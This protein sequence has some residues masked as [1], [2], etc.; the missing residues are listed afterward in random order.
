MNGVDEVYKYV[1]FDF[2]GTLVDSKMTF[3]SSWNI[4]AKK[5]NY[6]EI[7]IDGIEELSNL[8]M[9][10]KMTWLNIPFYRIPFIAPKIYKLYR[11]SIHDI[12]LFEGIKDMLVQLEKKGYKT[13][14]ISSNSK[15]NIRFF[16][17]QN[18]IHSVNTIYCSSNIFGKD[19]L[20]YKFLRD[21]QLKSSDVIY[22]GDEQRDIVACK[23]I[24]VKIIWVGWGYDSIE[25]IEKE[26]PDYQVYRPAEILKVI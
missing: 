22:V 11:N 10:E 19:K 18:N 21:H 3:I 6:R 14:I 15:E 23:K 1:I 9:K 12:Q 16:L 7:K 24:G 13:S 25:V 5:Y 2:D 20:I 26:K 17:E 4:L 8:S